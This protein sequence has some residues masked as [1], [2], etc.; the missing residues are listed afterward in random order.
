[1]LKDSTKNDIKFHAAAYNYAANIYE[2]E[3][4]RISAPTGTAPKEDDKNWL[5]VRFA[6]QK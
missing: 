4:K 5:T 3:R 6:K 1:M 2:V